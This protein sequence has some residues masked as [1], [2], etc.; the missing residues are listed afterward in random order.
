MSTRYLQLPSQLVKVGEK[1]KGWR[2]DKFMQHL[3][4]HFSRNSINYYLRQGAIRLN[5]RLARKGMRLKPG[6]E[7]DLPLVDQEVR[8]PF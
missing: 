1:E 6:D 4:P 7:V 5:N 2:L 3:C 8:K